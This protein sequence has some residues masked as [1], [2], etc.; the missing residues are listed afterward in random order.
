MGKATQDLRN[1]HDAILF[2]L[3]MLHDFVGSLFLSFKKEKPAHE[4]PS[5]FRDH[6]IFEALIP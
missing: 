3:Q 1:E 6:S 4:A 2:V 5:I